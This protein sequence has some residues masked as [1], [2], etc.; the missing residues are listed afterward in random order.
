MILWGRGLPARVIA[1]AAETIPYTLFCGITA[2]VR[3][4]LR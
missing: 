3:R 4:R 1:E 2:R